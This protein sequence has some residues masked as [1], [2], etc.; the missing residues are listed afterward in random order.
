MAKAYFQYYE[1]FEMFVL[2]LKTAE[3]R[4]SLRGKI[5]NYGFYGTE[6]ETLT[7]IEEVIWPVIKDAIDEQKHKRQVNKQNRAKREA[8]K[9]QEQVAKEEPKPEEPKAET[10]AEEKPKAKKFVKPTVEEITAYCAEHNCTINPQ[11]FYDYYEM[12]GWKTKAGPIKDW[13]AG[14]RT[15][16]SRQN[17]SHPAYSAAP[18]PRGLPEDRLT[19]D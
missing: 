14:V 12:R 17:E 19:F 4:D 13:R 18:P 5:I 2:Q 1:T 3:E 11:Q 8:A 7:A 16:E 10:P 9:A 15:W 6:P